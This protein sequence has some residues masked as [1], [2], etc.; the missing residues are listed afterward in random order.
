MLVYVFQLGFAVWLVRM[1]GLA[2]ISCIM[3][4]HK[5]PG[6]AHTGTAGRHKPCKKYMYKGLRCLGMP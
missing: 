5:P 6:P 3:Y 1:K 2:Y 4:I